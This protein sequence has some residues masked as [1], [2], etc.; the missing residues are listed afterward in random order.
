MAACG[1]WCPGRRLVAVVVDDDGH[2]TSTPASL[3]AA[4]D[5]ERWELLGH[6]DTVH[7]LDCELVLPEGL[8]K[9]DV[10]CR[11][12]LERRHVTWAAPQ[13]LVE[14]IRRVAALNSAAR[15]AAMLARLALVAPLRHHL[16][17]VEHVCPDRRQLRLL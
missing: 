4:D 12:A 9:T 6:L 17:R 13:A 11:F 1:V 10:I 3:T 15:T 5:D 16:R 7:G 2:V 14:A 8:V